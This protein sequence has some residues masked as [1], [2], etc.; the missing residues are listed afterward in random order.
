ML[1]IPRNKISKKSVLLLGSGLLAIGIAVF[2][3]IFVLTF[4][5]K[6]INVTLSP[7][8]DSS[9]ESHFNIS[10]AKKLFPSLNQTTPPT[11]E[12][13]STTTSSTATSSIP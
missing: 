4:L 2:L 5:V 12:I 7:S 13:P 3:I 1:K 9:S 6:N 8:S 11:T 10:G